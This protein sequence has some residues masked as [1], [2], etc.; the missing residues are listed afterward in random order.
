MHKH[1]SSF[2][3]FE[4][5]HNISAQFA[6]GITSEKMNGYDPKDSISVNTL[7]AFWYPI[8]HLKFGIGIGE[9]KVSGKHNYK[10]SV[11]RGTISY[12]YPVEKISIA[13]TLTIDSIGDHTVTAFGIAFSMGF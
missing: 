8:P 9:E 7:S 1:E 5:Q 10:A 13:P 12:E 2:V 4:Y 3:G 11:S 6:V